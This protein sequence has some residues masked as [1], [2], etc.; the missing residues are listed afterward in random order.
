M[1]LS[2]TLVHLNCVA[3]LFT[4]FFPLLSFI[5]IT[6]LLL[7]R[8]VQM[9]FVIIYEKEKQCDFEVGRWLLLGILVH[10]MGIG[11]FGYIVSLI[12]G[13][14][15]LL[16]IVPSFMPLIA[17]SGIIAVNI[18]SSNGFAFLMPAK[19]RNPPHAGL[20]LVYIIYFPPPHC[21][22]YIF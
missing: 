8:I 6:P 19:F 9:G 1:Y 4:R 18:W 2:F 16:I 7:S 10:S 20:F 14:Y 17:H 13:E 12:A 15:L 3:Q 11:I 21:F 5:F 22:N